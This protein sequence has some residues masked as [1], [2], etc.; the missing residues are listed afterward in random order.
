MKRLIVSSAI[1]VL[2]LACT[3]KEAPPADTAAPAAAGTQTSDITLSDVAGNWN[4]R[5]MPI[6]RD[7]TLLT[8]TVMA[9]GDT[10][11]RMMHLPN[12]PAVGMRISAAGDS[13]GGE[14]GP[15]QAVLRQHPMSKTRT[16]SRAPEG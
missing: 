12:R 1:A 7:T 14:A 15:Y 9:T 6:D 2:A 3:T 4:M 16:V 5:A 13:I 11:G 10:S 8:S